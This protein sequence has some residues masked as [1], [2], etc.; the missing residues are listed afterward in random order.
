MEQVLEQRRRGL[1]LFHLF[2]VDFKVHESKEDCDSGQT[3]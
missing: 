3:T 2:K 1:E